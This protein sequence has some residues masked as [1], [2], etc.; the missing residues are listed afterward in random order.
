LKG[1]STNTTLVSG[2]TFA[3]NGRNMVAT[4]NLFT[5]KAG[6]DFVTISATDG[7]ST[8]AQSFVLAVSTGTTNVPATLKKYNNQI[9]VVG[10][11]TAKASYAIESSTN[12]ST[13]TTVTN[14]TTDVTGK[15]TYTTP[16]SPS[17][18]ELFIRAH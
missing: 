1:I 4:I 15:F 17:V 18:K 14:V 12:L 13:W 2:I 9:T 8:A 10:T 11:G 6:V 3:Y 16:I 7:F 5:N